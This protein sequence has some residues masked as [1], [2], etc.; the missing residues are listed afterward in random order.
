MYKTKT[1]R[2]HGTI[3]VETKEFG[4]SIEETVRQAIATNQPIEGKAPMIYTPANE[5]VNAAYNIRT[6]KQDLALAANDKYQASDH[7][8]GFIGAVEYD[9]N[10]FDGKGNKKP[11]VTN[12]QNNNE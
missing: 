4:L 11:E 10:G 8:K 9:E 7:M 12:E 3:K 6:D 2:N 1:K 5:G